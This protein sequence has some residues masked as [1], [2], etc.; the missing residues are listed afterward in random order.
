M[1]PST[2]LGS[3]KWA[4]GQ[5]HLAL[6]SSWLLTPSRHV[7]SLQIT[8]PPPTPPP[9]HSHWHSLTHTSW[10]YS[11]ATSSTLHTLVSGRPTRPGMRPQ[12]ACLGASPAVP[13]TQLQ[14]SQS[15]RRS[16]KIG[17]RRRLRDH[18]TPPFI[19]SRSCQFLILNSPSFT[20][21]LSTSY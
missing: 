20:N 15:P 2:T 6:P 1:S 16:P 13:A 17:L 9:V 14:P 10:R 18:L 4:W 12:C 7:T 3:G 8:R 19:S 21:F 11:H 5:P